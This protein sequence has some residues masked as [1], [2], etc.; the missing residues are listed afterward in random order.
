MTYLELVQMTVQQSGTIQG[1]KPPTVAGQVDRLK[2]F[3][4]FVREAYLDIQNSHRMWRWLLSRFIGQT[5][6]GQ[7]FYLGTAFTDERD[8]VPVTRFSQW[9][10]KGDMSDAGLSSYTASIG[11][12]DEGPLRFLDIDRFY[13]TQGRGVQTPGKPQFYTVDNQNR[14]VL[15]PIPDAVYTLRGK[16]RKSAQVLTADSDVPE[17]P[18]DFHTLIKDA[19]LCYVEAFDEGP[20]IPVYRLRMLPNWS[21]L[22]ANQLP[23]VTWG[24]PLA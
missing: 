21:M 9:G 3:V 2:Q 17:M 23:Q 1:V 20:R 10:F 8:T 13:E 19:A 15:S 24:S 22:E 16:Y 5:V 4:D 14:L 12:A 6:V 18:V 7:R 11:P